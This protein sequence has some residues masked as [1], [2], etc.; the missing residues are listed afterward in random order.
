MCADGNKVRS[1]TQTFLRKFYKDVPTK[2]RNI[3]RT[4]ERYWAE[5]KDIENAFLRD[6]FESEKDYRDTL[7]YARMYAN[8][9]TTCKTII[10]DANFVDQLIECT[11]RHGVQHKMDMFIFENCDYAA[12]THD[13][14]NFKNIFTQLRTVANPDAKIV[15]G[16]YDKEHMPSFSKD[17]RELRMLDIQY[18]GMRRLDK[19]VAFVYNFVH[20][21]IVTHIKMP[22]M[23]NP[24]RQ[25]I[26]DA[27]FGHQSLSSTLSPQAPPAQH[28]RAISPAEMM[29]GGKSHKVYTGPKGGKYIL[30]G[31]AKR[32]VYL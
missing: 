22:K 12:F 27:R 13:I 28:S 31:S 21:P 14:K 19:D 26:R 29:Y 10:G 18:E 3:F 25:S 2:Y 4:G 24:A 5:Q 1:D 11:T 15:F 7:Q 20:Q 23:M 17:N 32:K 9:D 30:V 6:H 16:F 8:E